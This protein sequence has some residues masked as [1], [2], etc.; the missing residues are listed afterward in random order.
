MNRE[1]SLQIDS[2]MKEE[3]KLLPPVLIIIKLTKEIH[4]TYE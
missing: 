3:K 4:E 2:G 1:S